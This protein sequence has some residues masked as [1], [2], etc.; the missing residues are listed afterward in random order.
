MNKPITDKLST[1]IDAGVQLAITKA[2]ERHRLLGESISIWQDGQ[3]VTLTA[4][5]IPP[6]DSTVNHSC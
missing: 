1:T 5:Q 3:V 4:D 2:I 6:A